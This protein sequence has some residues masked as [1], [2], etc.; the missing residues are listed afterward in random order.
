MV[1]SLL[2]L[3]TGT[4]GHAPAMAHPVTWRT[5]SLPQWMQPQKLVAEKVR[6]AGLPSWMLPCV[7][8]AGADIGGDAVSPVF[9]DVTELTNTGAATS[10]A[11]K[12]PV[13]TE[14][15]S[16]R[17]E[18]KHKG[19]SFGTVTTRIHNDS[20]EEREAKQVAAAPALRMA[21]QIMARKMQAKSQGA[22]ESGVAKTVEQL[23][24]SLTATQISSSSASLNGTPIAPDDGAWAAAQQRV[25][26][27]QEHWE[28]EQAAAVIQRCWRSFRFRLQVRKYQQKVHDQQAA[29]QAAEAAAAAATAEAEAANRAKM[30]AAIRKNEIQKLL[31]RRE[32]AAMQARVAKKREQRQIRVALARTVRSAD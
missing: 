20:A 29:A 9:E 27:T 5:Q 30:S 17:T 18:Q 14:Q 12:K 28:H 8:K 25:C 3:N 16:K 6:G 26:K 15:K 31:L 24:E 19:L 4:P 7:A 11:P 32:T 22:I 13:G 23:L 21:G 1:L 2:P 10:H